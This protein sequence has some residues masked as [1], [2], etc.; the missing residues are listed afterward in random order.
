MNDRILRAAPP[1][2]RGSAYVLILAIA[3]AVVLI[4]LTAL[5]V[6][7]MQFRAASLTRDWSDAQALAQAGLD[8]GLLVVGTTVDAAEAANTNWRLEFTN[9]TP[10]TPVVVGRGSYTWM[11]SDEDGSLV[12][13]PTDAFTI[14]ATGTVD[15]AS[16]SLSALLRPDDPPDP[17]SALGSA[18]HAGQNFVFNQGTVIA[19]AVI[20][21]NGNAMASS[22]TIDADVEAAGLISGSTYGGTTTAGVA[23]RAMPM[24]WIFE[25]FVELG[26]TID[27]T[28]L[29]GERLNKEILSPAHNPTGGPTNPLG[30]Y[31]ID[32]QGDDFEMRYSRIVGTLVL[33]NAGPGTRVSRAV[34]AEPALPHF[35]SLLVQGN[36][37]LKPGPEHLVEDDRNMSFNP[38]HT[39]YMGLGDNDQDGILPGVLSGIVYA[40]GDITVSNDVIIEGVLIA[41]GA[42]QVEN[43]TLTVIYRDTFL[44]SPPPGFRSGSMP[45]RLV[46]GSLA[47]VVE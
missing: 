39:P 32:C 34:C 18:V 6:S 16:Y 26:T 5:H 24:D 30:I 33:L 28:Q 10:T 22:S 14:I 47:Q 44:T 4:G 46:P 27:K 40:S 23:P 43:D 41:G 12:D 7:H 36:I 29:A 19:D 20:S 8:A 13:D 21:C 25:R 3:T 15:E 31:V 37:D 2:R 42:I 45:I 38:P 35:P 17:I 1:R 9:E 11:L